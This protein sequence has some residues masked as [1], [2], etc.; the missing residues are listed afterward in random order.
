MKLSIV[1]RFP[2]PPE[3]LW[4]LFASAEFERRLED[5]SGV[6]MEETGTWTEGT[7]ECR[8]LKCVSKREL[9]SLVAKAIGSSHLTYDQVT[10]LDRPANRLEWE[11]I[12]AFL[13]D[14]VTAKGHTVA[15]AVPEGS[16]RRV[17][18]DITVRLPVIGGRIEKTILEQVE[19][20]YE[21]AAELALLMLKG[22]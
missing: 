8:R 10:R 1:N 14:K 4:D 5:T 15:F 6:R 2:C 9:P 17:E 16:E 3:Q 13:T 11:V 20:S 18:G 7:L 19:K 21:R 12:P 22:A